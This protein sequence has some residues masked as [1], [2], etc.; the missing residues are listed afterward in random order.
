MKQKV[1]DVKYRKGSETFPDWLKYEVTVLNEDGTTD[2]IPAYGKDLQDALSR[3]VHDQR[4]EKFE[5]TTAKFPWWLYAAGWFGYLIGV[6]YLTRIMESDLAA[7]TFGVGMVVP[8]LSITLL[9]RWA[10]N[11]NTRQIMKNG[12]KKG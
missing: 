7:L 9:N 1:I 2:L 4:V 8:V 5:E 10:I 6:V 3:V 12:R 11:K